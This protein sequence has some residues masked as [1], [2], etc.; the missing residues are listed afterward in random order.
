[1][2]VNTYAHDVAIN[3]ALARRL[4]LSG[5][6]ALMGGVLASTLAELN[7]H[8]VRALAT[9]AELARTDMGDLDRQLA[10]RAL[11]RSLSDD[12]GPSWERL[13][14]IQQRLE[15]DPAVSSSSNLMFASALATSFVLCLSSTTA[16]GGK[17]IGTA[18]AGDGTR[19]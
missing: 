11:I 6:D 8:R 2:G 9:A 17:T 18:G 14:G 3:V 15:K 4:G 7:R 16:C 10:M 12:L 19:D 5:Y 13:H 1:Y